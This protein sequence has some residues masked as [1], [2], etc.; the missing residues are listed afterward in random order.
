[1]YRSCFLWSWNTVF[2]S[3][4]TTQITS[5]WTQSAQ[6]KKYELSEKLRV[7]HNKELYYLYDNLMLLVSWKE[8]LELTLGKRNVTQEPG[9]LIN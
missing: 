5:I 6:E 9:R 8:I 4:W 2:H 7:L 3:K 1:M